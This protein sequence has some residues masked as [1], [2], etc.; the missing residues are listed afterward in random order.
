MSN[1]IFIPEEQTEIQK[2]FGSSIDLLEKEAFKTK[3]RELRTKFHPDNFAKFGDETVLTMATDR[4]QAIERLAAKME[5]WYNGKHLVA[6]SNAPSNAAP[7]FDPKAQFAIREMKI[8]IRTSDKDLKYHLF[9]TFYRWLLVGDKFNI[10]QTSAWVIADEEH[11]GHK[12]GFKETIRFYLTFDEKDQPEA[13]VNWFFEKIKDRADAILIE[14][15]IV[16]IDY[17]AIL[18]EVKRR[19]FLRIG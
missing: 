12:I 15:E 2:L 14:G 18:L 19:S 3:L 11:S 13:I 10:P 16:T 8:E 17:S 4:F 9:G 5:D 1:E 7:M 6:T